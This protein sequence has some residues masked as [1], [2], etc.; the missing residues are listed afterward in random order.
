MALLDIPWTDGPVTTN[1]PFYVTGTWYIGYRGLFYVEYRNDY[2]F[3]RL[4]HGMLLGLDGAELLSNLEYEIGP[5]ETYVFEFD[6]TAALYDISELRFQ[7]VPLDST[8]Y[9]HTILSMGLG[10]YTVPVFWTNFSGQTES[11]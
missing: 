8:Q 2:A 6:T 4:L 11:P 9:L 3:S 5:G 1:L 10:A 7:D